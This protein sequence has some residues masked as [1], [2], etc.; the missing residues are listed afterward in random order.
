MAD[1]K[2]VSLT[3]AASSPPPRL[4]DKK[5]AQAMRRAA[6]AS[7]G[8][9]SL[10]VAVKSFAYLATGSVAMLGALADSAVDLVASLGILFAVGHSLTPPDAEH[11][12]GHGKAEP[13][14]GLAQMLFIAG[15]ATYVAYEA[16][17]H[18]IAPEPVENP[19]AGV[20]VLL[21]SIAVTFALVLYQRRVVRQT[22]SPA[23]AAD[24]MHY[25]GD[26][27]TNLGAIAALL[28][29]TY[30]GWRLADPIIGLGIAAVLYFSAWTVF[31][32]SLDQLMDREMP[33]EDRE[34][35]KAIIAEHPAVKGVHDLRTRLAGTQSFIQ[36][37]IEMDPALS[38]G[39]AHEASEEIDRRLRAAFPR[40]EI[41]IHLDPFGRDAPSPLARS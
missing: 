39:D 17:R 7:V 38:L 3:A 13:L 6:L 37:H 23:I 36:V 10:L 30:L 27:L 26:L 22:G 21:F 14:I 20:G 2:A 1:R 8:T 11:R 5:L 16:I 15:S 29:S 25:A 4:S 31:R 34:R 41:L 28:L 12:F 24:N 9:A 19:F 33:D 18:L 32:A 35:I 40:I